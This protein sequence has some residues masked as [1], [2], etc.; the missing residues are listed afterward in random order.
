[1]KN[2][3]YSAEFRTPL[4]DGSG[5]VTLIDGH[6]TGG[7]AILYYVGSYSI[8]GSTFTAQV[9]TGRHHHV[10]GV[11]SV[12]GKDQVTIELSGTINGDT[13]EASGSATEA[14]SVKFSAKLK[15][16]AVGK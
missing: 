15:L 7:D 3:L 5:V 13:L 12:F 1:M 10:P 4:G 6:L 2:G 9:T 14:P 16:V 11:F 8:A